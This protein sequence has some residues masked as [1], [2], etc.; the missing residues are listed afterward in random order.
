MGRIAIIDKNKCKPSKC[1]QECIKKCPV[2][3]GGKQ[4]IEIMDIED[5]GKNK[6]AKINESLCTGCNMCV[7]VCPFNAIKIINTPD[8]QANDIV[9]R[10]GENGFRLYK[11][12][13]LKTNRVLTLIGQNGI[14]KS[15]IVDI[16]SGQCIPNFEIF[17]GKE[18]NLGKK[19]KNNTLKKYFSDLKADKLT[20]SIK[21][22][23]IRSVIKEHDITVQEYIQL[24]DLIVNEK[25]IDLELHN[26]INNELN[27]LSGGE[28]QCLLCWITANKNANVYIF[29][30]PSNFLDI[31]Q[32]MKIG[33]MIK[34]LCTWNTCVLLVE[35]DLSLVDYVS[36]EIDILYGKPGAYGIVNE[37]SRC[38][39]VINEYLDG[40]LSNSNTRFR[41]NAFSLLPYVNLK[42]TIVKSSEL[43]FYDET[44]IEYPGFSLHVPRGNVDL[45]GSINV[46]LGENGTGK[47]TF[48]KYLVQNN[49]SVS[50][51]DQY[52]NIKQYRVNEQY[53]T[54]LELLYGNIY[55][56]PQF[57]SDVVNIL[58]IEP[59]ENKFINELSGGELQRVL[60]C[61]TLSQPANIY[62]LDEPSANLDIE[63]RL[64]CIKAFKKY[65]NKSNKCL[66]IIE[67]DIMMAV[68]L[69]Q[70]VHSKIL[71]V[72][73]DRIEDGIKYCHVS[74]PLDFNTGINTFLEEIDI[75]MRLA[76]NN[77]PRINKYNSQ[78]DKYQKS[79]GC[80]YGS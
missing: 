52:S 14:G 3:R 66:F 64:S 33:A 63:N 54:V 4:V 62:L 75:T 10:Y 45:N 76:A 29:D 15:T 31:K 56:D 60:I 34:D 42:N 26:L 48:I 58:N 44:I 57:K 23:K 7:K 37:S 27:T 65:A 71:F 39:T 6:I 25:F 78:I 73:K 69:A 19:F 20:F 2:Q 53:P 28:L 35:H 41:D 24:F 5:L 72:K 70:E 38:S 30:E 61:K 77:R 40:Y 47:S 55:N 59:L 49:L 32:R 1:K 22:Q 16:L 21:P 43:F 8:E 67:H 11:L 80:Y 50:Y 13:E 12:P 17:D 74:E 36:D 18:I 46:I 79:V 68:S 9:H 51:K